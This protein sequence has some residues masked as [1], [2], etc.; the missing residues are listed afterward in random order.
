[1]ASLAACAAAGWPGFKAR[2]SGIWLV[3]HG[4]RVQ[5]FLLL[6][7]RPRLCSSACNVTG[8]RFNQETRVHTD[9]DNVVGV[10]GRRLRSEDVVMW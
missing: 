9:K 8:Q 3:A 10:T 6:L 4:A 1:M 5:M 7:L 2:G